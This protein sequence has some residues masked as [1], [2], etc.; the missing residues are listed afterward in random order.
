MSDE[1]DTKDRDKDEG[2]SRRRTSSLVSGAQ[3]GATWLR[4]LHAAGL[5]PRDSVVIDEDSPSSPDTSKN[6]RLPDALPVPDPDPDAA[7]TADGPDPTS[8][9]KSKAKAKAKANPNPN[10]DAA[11]EAKPPGNPPAPPTPPARMSHPALVVT[12]DG[13]PASAHDAT[14]AEYVRPAPERSA[15]SPALGALSLGMGMGMGAPAQA[16]PPRSPPA[17]AQTPE[18]DTRPVSNMLDGA[19]EPSGTRVT[20]ALGSQIEAV[21]AAQEEIGKR[22]LALEG[23]R[24]GQDGEHPTDARDAKDKDGDADG[25]DAAAAAGAASGREL[26]K[27]AQGVEDIMAR[28]STAPR[29]VVCIELTAAR[30]ALGRAQDVPRARH[31]VA[32]VPREQAGRGRDPRARCA[33]GRH[34]GA[35]RPRPAC[36]RP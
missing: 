15:S 11:S 23:W 28:V 10:P 13:P 26:E 20:R 1:P 27:R 35:P 4:I 21:L 30:R 22:H 31:A 16:V 7:D 14:V 17:P 12:G 18:A 5:R 33:D 6:T 8:K 24:T 32:R 9:S 29:G 3:A 2:E 36:S 25:A 34:G 19:L